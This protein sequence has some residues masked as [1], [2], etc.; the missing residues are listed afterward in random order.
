MAR[1]LLLQ[2]VMLLMLGAAPGTPANAE[3]YSALHFAANGNFGADG[4]YLPGAIGFNLA[5]VS[6]ASQLDSLPP[7]VKGLAWVGQCHGVDA[8]FI[9]TVRPYIGNPRLFGFHLMDDPDPRS[10]LAVLRLFP[11]CAADNLK[12][13]SDWIHAN[14]P[15]AKTFITL[16]SLSS[17]KRPSFHDT[18]NPANSHVDLY[19][20]D[21][22]PCRTELH[23]C[24]YDMIDRFVSAAVSSGVPRESIVPIYQTFG[25]GDWNDGDGGRYALPTADEERQLLSRWGTLVQ[26]PVFDYAYSWGSQRR[27]IGLESASDL[28]TVFSDHNS[29]AASHDA[30]LPR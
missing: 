10:G 14:A 8:A 11:T 12:A 7:G 18:Y 21:P 30:V 13:E 24:D 25:G 29:A 19:G 6:S 17:S 22:Y 5:D 20:V 9:K 3:P 27:D 2:G 4:T 26:T 1:G 15:G 23:G 16:M 28:R